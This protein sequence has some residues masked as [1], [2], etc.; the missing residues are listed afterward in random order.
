MLHLLLWRERLKSEIRSEEGSDTL[1]PH[2][3]SQ[4]KMH[5]VDCV[6][7]TVQIVGV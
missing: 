3:R 4:G 7:V 2:G 1:T 5:S 6:V